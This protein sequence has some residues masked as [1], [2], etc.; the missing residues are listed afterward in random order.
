M[1]V[2]ATRAEA[3]K[4]GLTPLLA[5]RSWAVTGCGPEVMGIGPF[6]ATTA[7]LDR[8]GLTLDEIDLIELNE[9]F[10][11]QVLA[12]DKLF[13]LPMDRVNVNGGAV[14]LGHPLGATGARQTVTLLHEAG[15]RRS[16]W[17]LVS[18]CAALGM[19]A[20]GLFEFDL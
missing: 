1:C 15:R 20:A 9:A 14:A 8:A 6:S 16:K 2:V 19:G 5:L 12:S 4:R 17:G 10:A 7:A 13:A 11:A 3:D 18:I